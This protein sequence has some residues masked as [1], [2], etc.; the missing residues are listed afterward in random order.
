MSKVIVLAGGTS[1]EKEV[2]KRS[3]SAVTKALRTAGYEAEMADPADGLDKLLP[4]LQ[5]ADVIFPALHGAGGEDGTVQKFLEDHELCYVGSDSQASAL[6]FDKWR[7]KQLLM[8]NNLPVSR[9]ELVDET[10]FWRSALIKRPF[11]LKPDDGGSSIDNLVMRQPSPV[12]DEQAVQQLFQRHP[13]MLLEELILGTEIT[14]AVVGDRSLPVIEIIPPSDQEFDYENKYNGATQELCPPVHVSKAIQAEAQKLTV[15]IHHL[16]GCRDL[17]RT[18]IMIDGRGQ[19]FVLE[20]NTIPGLTDQS[21]LPGAAATAGLSM[22]QLC[23]HLVKLA[24]AR[25]SGN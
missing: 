18:D 4:A 23:D 21:L 13:K 7:Y 24:L 3:G 15:R 8:T 5:A 17:S 20:T 1:D 25:K 22:T 14:I 6:C 2:S 16:T 11:I 19:L 10:S 9:G 12:I